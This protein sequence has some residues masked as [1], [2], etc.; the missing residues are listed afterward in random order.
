MKRKIFVPRPDWVERC[1]SVGFD[2][3]N[4]LSSDG[5]WYWSEGVGYEFS[6]AQIDALEDATN[7]LHAMCME[8]VVAMI[9]SGDYP[10]QYGLSQA[11]IALIESSW[12]A[13]E[14]SLYGRFDLAYDGNSIKMLEYNAD[15]PT[16]L[17]EASVVQWNWLQDRGLPD[18]FNSIHER[19]I[20]RWKVIAEGI[21]LKPRIY[22][23]GMKE[24]G[25]EDWGNIEYLMDTAHQAGFDTSDIVVDDIGW[26]QER[27][28]FVDLNEQPIRGCFKLYPWEWM[29][30]DGFGE[31]IAQSQTRFIEPAW[32]M[33]LSSKALLPL[34]WKQFE[35]H[36]LLLP[37]FFEAESEKTKH[38]KW[39]RKPILA[40]EGAN[41]TKV[42]DGVS[43]HLTG[44]AFNAEYDKS[45]YV[46]QQWVD[47][48]V[49]DGFRPLV[50]S[51]IIGDEAA[52]IGVRED[53]N[54][55]TGNDSHF[56]PHYFVG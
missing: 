45:G 29:A 12:K 20:E 41:V 30:R 39:V 46:L 18:Q 1:K 4:L 35:G 37:T 6:L 31:S 27:K 10:L 33:L 23:A 43:V 38:G 11:A 55:V 51:W 50:G 13:N 22:F 19:L 9:K 7:A 14:P 52:G 34:L 24:A 48:P 26:D 53:Y 28:L 49:F 2:Y 56:V 36:P 44:S 17:L 5:S 25:R 15:T 21:A 54:D 32:K 40:R 8:V 47:L 3:C 16:S 42:E